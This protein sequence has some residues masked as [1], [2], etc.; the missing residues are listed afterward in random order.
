MPPAQDPSEDKHDVLR[1]VF[2][3]EAFRPGQEAIIDTLLAGRN[4]LAVMPT[5]SGKSLC[6]QLP[7]LVEDGLTVVVSP[8]VAL[9][10]DQVSALRLAGIAAETINS[11][12]D[13]PDNVAAWRRVAAGQVRLLYMAPE[14]LMTERMLAALGRLPIRQIVVDEAHCIS[15]W[16]PAFRPEYEDLSRLPSLFPGLPMAAFTA[17]A[18]EITRREIADKLFAGAADI[19]V[20]GFDRPN[21]RLA[22]EAKR[23]WRR[24]LL[25]F[26]AEHPGDS[27]IV[28]C[29]SRKKTEATAELLRQH[30]VRA[31]PYHAG[32]A[33]EDREANQN[34]FM[35]EAGVVVVA[36]IA[37]GMGIDKPDVR[38]VVH[39]DLPGSIETY[40]Q[41]FGRAGRDGLPAR[42]LLLHGLDDIRMRRLFVEEQQGDEDHKRREHKR[43]DALIAYCEAASCRRVMLL[44]YFGETVAPCGNCDVCLEPPELVEGTEEARHALAAVRDTGQ[45]FGAAH[46]VDVLRGADTAKIAKFAHERLPAYGAG[47]EWPKAQWHSVI[48]QLVAAN[49][50][51]LD[52]QGH[53]GLSLTSGGHELL[54]GQGG[55]RY[56][57]DEWR[58]KKQP[59][60]TAAAAPPEAELDPAE[61]SLLMA[62]K[63][64]RRRLA[65]ERGVPAY[66]VFHDRSLA[67]M[68]RRRPQSVAD[69]GQ[70]H[71]VGEAKSRDFAEVFLAAIA[72]HAD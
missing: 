58:R 47:A 56:R 27:G 55:F 12:R 39:T 21:I 7:A 17:T 61:T 16:G 24:Q 4:V 33:K 46:I 35:T 3:F 44:R 66:V 53:G 38:F 62:L 26:V 65:G 9:M 32:M 69:F 67:D 14:R 15:Q 22:A 13:R 70:I 41:E 23:D 34:T 43:L 63:E 64:L 72:E 19:F 50:L 60:R 59:A 25:D 29:L 20:H 11:S 28:Y 1:R 54:A 48:R 42:A 2:G 8:L 52:I 57:Q 30:G 5:G 71:G 31:L 36:T 6:F 45:R 40:Y 18:D 68:A 10:R 51:V 49:H 37:F